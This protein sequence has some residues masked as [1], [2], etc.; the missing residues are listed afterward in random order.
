MILEEFDKNKNAT[1][2]PCEVQNVIPGFPKIAVS[3][4]SIK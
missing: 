4:F 2:D 3:C 1:F